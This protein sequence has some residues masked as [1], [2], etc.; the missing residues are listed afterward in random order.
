M[1]KV[2]ALR[3]RPGPHPEHRLDASKIIETAKHLAD[4]INVRLSGSS[5]AGLAEELARIAVAT[6]ERGRQARR[7]IL[8][9]RLFSVLAI[10]LALLGLW[11]LA[12]HIHTRW[13]FGTIAEFFQAFNAGFNLLVLLAGSLWFFVTLETRIKR[14]EVLEFI[15]ELREFVH[16]IDVTQLYYTPDLYRS[17]HGGTPR[18]L[19]IDE[20]YLL[21]CVQMLAVISNLAPLYS[22]G[23]IGDSI[24]R[25]ASE[26]EMLAIAI[27]T[28]H[29]A[30]AAAIWAMSR[31][32]TRQTG[33]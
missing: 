4:D 17:R 15:E 1:P 31:D 22:R 29:L 8:A 19:A 3:L 14:R 7:P 24:L 5:L 12:R 27:T 25:A 11:Y 10:C 16:V 13:E 20:T 26:V 9:I 33:D 18:N 28:K 23:A 21:Y 6:D 30:K 32:P 2:F